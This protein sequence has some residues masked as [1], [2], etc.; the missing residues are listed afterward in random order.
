MINVETIKFINLMNEL[1]QRSA[2]GIDDFA[3]ATEETYSHN[4]TPT[5]IWFD[6]EASEEE[7]EFSV[8]LDACVCEGHHDAICYY[9]NGEYTVRV[10]DDGEGSL[11]VRVHLLGSNEMIHIHDGEWYFA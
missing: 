5:K 7:G 10:V 8:V 2:N 11:Y 3:N 1:A 6:Q 9:G 4:G